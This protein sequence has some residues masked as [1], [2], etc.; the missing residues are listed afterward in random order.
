[1]K[2]ISS[3]LYI[4]LFGLFCICHITQA[5]TLAELLEVIKTA[6]ETTND[7]HVNRCKTVE[8]IYIAVLG[9][10]RKELDQPAAGEDARRIAD[11][12]TNANGDALTTAEL[13]EQKNVL[14]VWIANLVTEW[15]LQDFFAALEGG[16]AAIYL[17][18]LE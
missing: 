12:F 3:K 10:I 11:G 1:M 14:D 13:H 5:R 4:L 18:R 16:N 2:N 15:E 6:K 17:A 9:A 7:E 8:K